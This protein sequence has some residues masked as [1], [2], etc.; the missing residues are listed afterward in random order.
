[1]KEIHQFGPSN[2]LYEYVPKPS[3]PKNAL[4]APASLQL[5]H[6]VNMH[7]VV[8]RARV[9]DGFPPFECRQSLLPMCG[10]RI[11]HYPSLVATRPLTAQRPLSRD[12]PELVS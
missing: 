10:H 1:M 8:S 7:G 11:S 3:R 5:L 4:Q 12:L 6:K 9:H 2:V